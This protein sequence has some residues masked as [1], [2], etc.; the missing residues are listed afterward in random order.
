MT[1][2][3]TGKFALATCQRCG[4]R[5]K[6]S[7]MVEDG[8]Y[9]GLRVH[10]DCYDMKNPAERPFNAEDGIALKHPVPDLDRGVDGTQFVGNTVKDNLPPLDG[11]MFGGGS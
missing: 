5:G 4:M 9:K 10:A 11:G 2:L 1:K 7:D 6:Y 3:A 8:Q